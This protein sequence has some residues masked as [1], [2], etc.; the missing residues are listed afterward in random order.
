MRNVRTL[1]C[2]PE[3]SQTTQASKR[4]LKHST[5]TSGLREFETPFVSSLQP[6]AY[7]AVFPR[8]FHNSA[9]HADDE[10]VEKTV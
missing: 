9:K 6:L 7:F 8:L 2:V 4:T 5:T 1:A 10:A 3:P